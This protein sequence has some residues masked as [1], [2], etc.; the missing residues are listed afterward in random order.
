MPARARPPGRMPDPLA[1][2]GHRPWGAGHGRLGRRSPPLGRGSPP[3]GRRSPPSG[4]RHRPSGAGRP[5]SAPLASGGL[6]FL[7]RGDFWVLR[8]RNPPRSRKRSHGERGLANFRRTI[9]DLTEKSVLCVLSFP[10]G[11]SASRWG[12]A[13]RCATV[14]GD[15]LQGKAA[16]AVPSSAPVPDGENAAARPPVPARPPAAAWAPRANA[17]APRAAAWAPLP[18]RLLGSAD[19]VASPAARRDLAA[20]RVD[21]RLGFSVP[22]R[23]G[24]LGL[25]GKRAPA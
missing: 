8:P 20:L 23:L 4:P 18:A 24:L 16:G 1:P 21:S 2:A 15:M 3:L 17:W 7:D 6:P 12:C 19:V 10:S 5:V 9:N 13:P 14:R 11:V 22:A 25:L